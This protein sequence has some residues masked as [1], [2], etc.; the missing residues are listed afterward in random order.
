MNG[1]FSSKQ[2][3]IIF[4]T[5]K[6]ETP[7]PTPIKNRPRRRVFQLSVVTNMRVPIA[8]VEIARDVTNLKLNLSSIIPSGI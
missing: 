2:F 8:A 1:I 3:F 4:A 5:D 6:N 7:E